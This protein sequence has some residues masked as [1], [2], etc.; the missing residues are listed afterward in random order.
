MFKPLQH[1]R[2]PVV[3]R[4]TCSSQPPPREIKTPLVFQDVSTSK[5][6]STHYSGPAALPADA[7]AE[8][9]LSAVS[10]LTNAT[11]ALCTTTGMP[12]TAVTSL[13]YV[14]VVE[15]NVLNAK[16]L[17]KMLSVRDLTSS[18]NYHYL[19]VSA[20]TLHRHTIK[21]ISPPMVSKL[22]NR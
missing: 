6:A 14:L 4:S 22:S 11:S 15:D 16:M 7:A 9:L 18:R 5:A 12:L 10:T 19:H 2:I 21:S 3:I 17:C 20:N 13:R 8:K 1:R